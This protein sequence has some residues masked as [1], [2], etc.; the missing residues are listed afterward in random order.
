MRFSEEEKV[1]PK[2]KKSR[3]SSVEEVNKS[4]MVVCE[5]IVCEVR[6]EE[7]DVEQ[8]IQ[9]LCIVHKEK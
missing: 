2:C 8:R 3:E 6:I 4:R 1:E 5:D 9:G 7:G